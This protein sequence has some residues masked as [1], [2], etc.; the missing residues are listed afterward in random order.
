MAEIIWDEAAI[1]SFPGA[2]R[3]VRFEIR[4]VVQLNNATELWW[5]DSEMSPFNPKG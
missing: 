3:V 1:A 2:G 4:D 5:E